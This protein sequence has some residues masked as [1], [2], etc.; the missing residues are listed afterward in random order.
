MPDGPGHGA[1]GVSPSGA[2]DRG[3][4]AR[5]DAAV[6]N[7]THATAL[8]ALLGPVRLRALAPTVLAVAGGAG[9]ITVRR[10]DPEGT[11]LELDAGQGLDRAIALD[12]GDV[13]TLGVPLQGLR[14]L[15]AVRGGICGVKRASDAAVRPCRN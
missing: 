12:P 4:L 13:L 2:F 15:V 3:A 7:R 6:G 14:R 11:A 5:A 9:E 8:E 10:A 1:I